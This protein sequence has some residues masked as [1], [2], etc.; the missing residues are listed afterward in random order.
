MFK[1]LQKLFKKKPPA[2]VADFDY[3]HESHL[4]PAP[5]L[6]PVTAV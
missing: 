4:R 6:V 2:P 3:T 5:P 1:L